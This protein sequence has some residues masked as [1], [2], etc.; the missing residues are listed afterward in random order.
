MKLK[1]INDNLKIRDYK[2][3]KAILSKGFDN[4]LKTLNDIT[5]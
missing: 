3:A 2:R 4:L 1:R 5:D